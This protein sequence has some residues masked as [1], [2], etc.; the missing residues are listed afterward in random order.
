MTKVSPW[1][2][3]RR[4]DRNVFHDD[5]D[6]PDG[7]GIALQY[8]KSG[9]RCRTRCPRCAKLERQLGASERTA[10]LIPLW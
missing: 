6:C 7:N 4:S 8:R 10:R 2:S 3:I 1:Y 5:N 9:H